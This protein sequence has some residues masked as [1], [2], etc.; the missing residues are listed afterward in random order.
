MLI[1]FGPLLVKSASELADS[2]SHH[3][4]AETLSQ[5]WHE[6][7]KVRK[8]IW[9]HIDKRPNIKLVVLV[10]AIGLSYS[11][12]NASWIC[13]FQMWRQFLRILL[14]KRQKCISM[15]QNTAF[16]IND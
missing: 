4:F 5:M 8:N 11:G 10:P 3:G 6:C 7:P 1:H 12:E 16:V 2:I 9:S 15:A 14:Q 13:S